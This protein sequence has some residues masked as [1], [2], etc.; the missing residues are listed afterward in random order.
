MTAPTL[1]LITF[2]LADELFAVE[3]STVERVLRYQRPTSLPGLPGWIE[4]V[5]DYRERVVPVFTLRMRLGLPAATP[6]METRVIVFQL[7]EEWVGGV[8]DA[9]VEVVT[10][11]R[12][13]LVPPPALFRG[14]PA[15]YLRG[16]VRR[17]DRLLI[18]L[19]LPQLLGSTERLELERAI[20]AAPSHG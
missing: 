19:D 5:V 14:L 20:E 12:D 1:E 4:G 10:V 8:V 2:R 17:D 11:S 3:I 9:V 16:L 7:G 18:L 15:E 13:Q 6:R